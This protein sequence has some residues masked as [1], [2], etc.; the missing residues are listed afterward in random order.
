MAMIKRWTPSLKPKN[1]LSPLSRSIFYLT[2]SLIGLCLSFILAICVQKYL[3]RSRLR[4][5]NRGIALPTPEATVLD[6]LLKEVLRFP[7]ERLGFVGSRSKEGDTRRRIQ[8]S[9]EGRNE[10]DDAESAI[11]S[12]SDPILSS[13]T[14]EDYL[15]AVVRTVAD[16]IDRD[17]FIK[18][19]CGDAIAKLGEDQFCK[20]FRELVQNFSVQLKVEAIQCTHEESGSSA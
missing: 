10:A 16:I 1:G 9:P 19:L 14:Q 11:L 20:N 2:E 18:E 8:S 5:R 4:S 17:P 13:F 6:Q 7:D 3:A 12:D 15:D